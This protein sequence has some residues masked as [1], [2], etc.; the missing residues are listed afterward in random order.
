MYSSGPSQIILAKPSPVARASSA[1]HGW[2]VPVTEIPRRTPIARIPLMVHTSPALT[3]ISSVSEHQGSVW[4]KYTKCFEVDLGRKY[5]VGRRKRI[6]KNLV[7]IRQTDK[8][9]LDWKLRLLRQLR[10]HSSF[11]ACFEV[12][13]VDSSLDVHLVCEYVDLNLLHLMQVPVV[14]SEGQ[15]AAVAGQVS[16]STCHLDH[17]SSC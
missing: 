3:V 17:K 6:F 12:F 13:S 7:L 9:M 15:V 11:I 16:I 8:T 4:E 5:A 1:S 10:T 14:P 2:Q